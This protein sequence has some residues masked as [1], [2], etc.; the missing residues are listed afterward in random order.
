MRQS[1]TLRWT[2]WR[3]QRAAGSG[4]FGKEQSNESTLQR[5]S[6]DERELVDVGRSCEV[7]ERLLPPREGDW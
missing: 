2:R 5:V 7:G 6:I 3:I 4:M 1:P